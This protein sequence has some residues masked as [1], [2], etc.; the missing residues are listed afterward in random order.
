MKRLLDTLRYGDSSTKRI[1]WSMLLF[2]VLTVVCVAFALI[3]QRYILFGPA[4]I[5]LAVVIVIVQMYDFSE[6][7]DDKLAELTK[8]VAPEDILVRYTQKHIKQ[9]FVR[10]RVKPDH[11]QILIDASSH[12]KIS[13]TPG[14]VWVS[15][16]Q[17]HILLLE[18]EVRQI[19]LP[20]TQVG[21]IRYRRAVP[22]NPKGEYIQF[23]KPSL[24]SNLFS[25]FL[26][27]VYEHGQGGIKQ[28]YKNL[29]MI[30]EDIL[31]SA[32]SARQILDLTGTDFVISDKLTQSGEYSEDLVEMYQAYTLFRDQVID[33]NEYKQKVMHILDDMAV[34]NMLDQEL[35]LNLDKMQSFRFITPDYATYCLEKRVKYLNQ[36]RKDRSE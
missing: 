2:S 11:R 4:F 33:A 18:K 20:L 21:P 6:I 22:V 31:I 15:R 7:K 23:R 36:N 14:Y 5:C 28:R 12:Y 13:Q 8:P 30:G 29:Y 10:F 35:T 17:L 34:S 1:L 26:P 3:R 16:N 25:D 19:M 9:I 24:L 27:R 32:K